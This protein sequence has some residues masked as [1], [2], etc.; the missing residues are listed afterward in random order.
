RV[1]ANT[2]PTRLLQYAE[3]GWFSEN[4]GTTSDSS[5]FY[6]IAGTQTLADPS[7]AQQ[8]LH[9]RSSAQL[10]ILYYAMVPSLTVVN[11]NWL[12]LRSH[13]RGVRCVPRHAGAFQGPLRGQASTGAGRAASR[14]GLLV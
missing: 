11:P 13:C 6:T 4:V 9:A 8:A 1:V 2:S 5:G 10:S 3:P 14:A 12:L 7:L